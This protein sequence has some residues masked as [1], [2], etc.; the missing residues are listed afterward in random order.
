MLRKSGFLAAAVFLLA[1]SALAGTFGK[2]VSIGGAASD[3]ALDEPRGVLYIANFTANRIDIMSLQSNTIQT[4][5]NVAAQPSAVSVS[6]DGHWLLVAHYGNNAAPAS[7]TN[8]LTLIDLRNNY[9]KQVFVLPDPPLGLAFGADNRAL[10][11]TTKN[12]LLFDPAGTTTVLTSIAAQAAK[13]LPV[14]VQNF[15]PNIVAASAAASPDGQFIWGL[16]D[17]L[18]FRYTVATGNLASSLYTSSP[19]LAPRTVSVSGDGSFATLGWE[20]RD[21]SFYNVAQFP[22]AGGTL[23]IGTTQIDSNRRLI[24]A[25]MSP[26]T[27]LPT[28]PVLQF[29]DDDNL[30]VRESFQLPENAAGK[31]ALRKDGSVMYSVSDSGVLVLPVGNLNQSPRLTASVEDLVFRGNFCDR[32]VATQT[33]VITDPGGNKTPFTISSSNPGVRVSASSLTTPAVITVSVDPNV[34]QD[35]KGTAAV[36]LT[37]SSTQSVNPPSTIRVL[38]NS[39]EPNQRGSIINIPGTLKDLAA[40]PVRDQYYVLRQDRNQVLVY[41]GSNNTKI[42]TLRTCT[43]PM[44][45][46]ITYDRQFLLVGCDNSHYVWVYDLDTFERQT[47]IRMSTGDYVQS[48]AASANA[49]LAV[50]RDSAGGSPN[51][52]RLDFTS[53]S[54]VSLASLGVWENRV[55]LDTM[56]SGSPNG[57]TIVAASS[58]GSVLLYDAN[59]D[60]FTISRKDFRSLTGAVAASAYGQYVIGNQ[61]FDSSLVPTATI[62][63]TNGNSSGF[64]FLDQNGLFVSAADSASPGVLARV[65]AS[66]GTATLPTGVVEAPRLGATGSGVFTRTL[67]MLANRSEIVVLSTS[68]ITVLPPNYDAPVAAPFI[69]SVVSAADL[70][71]PVAP[72]GLMSVLGTNLSATNLATNEIPLP[73]ALNDSC[74]IVNGQ[75]VHMLFVSPAQV[76]AQMPAQAVGNVSIAMHTPGGVSNTFLLNVLPGAP[77]VFRSISGDLTNVPTVVRFFNGLMVTSTNPVHRGD[78]LTIYLTGLGAVNPPIADGAPAPLNPLST[79]LITPSVQ[80]G[81][82]DCPVLF[83]GLVPGYVGLYV[84]NVSVPSSTPQGLSV[85]LTISEGGFSYSQNVRVVQQQ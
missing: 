35:F 65:N 66:N 11:V 19:A 13:S 24:Y 30:T 43:T 61:I 12:F 38:V 79:T 5:L 17:T 1:G 33:F 52:H 29:V 14:P 25:Q 82:A 36:T 60:T 57:S 58:D 74:L 46:T 62:Q 48:V 51:I 41:R 39:R 81:G 40:D 2:V 55:P 45:M 67:A 20:V 32:T 6:P 84:L 70:A 34:F 8:G 23:N 47:S 3:L 18:Q 69:S 83:S 73:T 4:S 54:S 75:P 76:N 22:N 50:T 37:L 72:G 28:P 7:P 21:S 53:R 63:P 15:P 68:G 56:L 31:S 10:V 85:P 71:S 64:L 49:I 44:S 16:G 9:A 78:I 27:S 80:I 42:A 59:V 26:P 77:A